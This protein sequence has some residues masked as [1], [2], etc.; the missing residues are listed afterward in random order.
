ML[1]MFLVEQY[2]NGKK[3]VLIVDEAQNL[4]KS[5]LEEVRMLSSI[6]TD[7]E[8]ILRIILAGQP[9]LKDTLESP[10]LKQLVQRV[11]LQFHIKPL[12]RRETQEY[13]THRLKVAGRDVAEFIVDDAFEPIYRYSGGVP[14]LINTLCDTALLCGFAEDRHTIDADDIVAAAEELNWIEH[15][16]STG[17]FR[18]LPHL[19]PAP[20]KPG[21]TTKIE[22][23]SDGKTL[24]EHF[25][26]EG[27][28]VVGRSPDNEIYIKSRFVSRHHAELINDESGCF[29]K[30]L[31]STNGVFMGDERIE[32]RQLNDGDIVKLGVHELIY[33]DLRSASQRSNKPVAKNRRA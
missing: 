15:E 31:N 5:V 33:S 17:K 23:R 1:N 13:V 20:T 2:A 26:G 16:H 12:D 18:E 8:K 22:L 19:V 6:E 29:I 4:K 32:K 14:R 28:A 27:R 21:C 24:S 30:D 25:F 9:E 7:K 11:R 3:I 10:K